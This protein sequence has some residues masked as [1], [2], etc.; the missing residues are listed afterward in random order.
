VEQRRLREKLALLKGG[1]ARPASDFAALPNQPTHGD[2][3]E[4]NVLL[5]ED[6]AVCAVV[7]W[8]RTSLAPRVFELL[9]AIAFM[10]LWEPPLLDAYLS[11][12]RRHVQLEADECALG[13]EMWWQHDLHNTWAFRETFIERDQRIAQFLAQNAARLAVFRDA[14]FRRELANALR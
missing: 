11:G 1:N 10:R 2:Y 5:D 7:D 9:R 8:E 14:G 6:G 3:H 13:V 12:Y 4:R